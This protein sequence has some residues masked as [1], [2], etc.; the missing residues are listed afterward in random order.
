MSEVGVDKARVRELQ[1]K[2]LSFLDDDASNNR[3]PSASTPLPPPM[4]P[5]RKRKLS[6]SSHGATSGTG[7]EGP[8]RGSFGHHAVPG[9]LT[10]LASW[11]TTQRAARPVPGI[12][13]KINS[14]SSNTT[15]TAAASNHNTSSISSTTSSTSSLSGQSKSINQKASNN[16][17]N[18]ISAS[19]NALQSNSSKAAKHRYETSLGQLTKKFITLLKQAPEGVLNLNEA[20]TMLDVQKRRIYD[21]TNVLEGV[22]LLEKTSKN[23]IRWNGGLLDED[24]PN[25]PLNILAAT[26]SSS[27]LLLD[28]DEEESS[29]KRKIQLLLDDIDA[30]EKMLDE[31]I[32]LATNE[33]NESSENSANKKYAYVTYRDIRGIKEFSD[34]T[35]IAIKA[36]SE[37]KLEVPDPR[38]SLQIWLKSD[39]GE[40]E[41]YLCPED[42]VCSS[43]SR[44]FDEGKGESLATDM[45][46]KENRDDTEKERENKYSSAFISEDEDMAPIGSN[47]KYQLPVLTDDHSYSQASAST[48][49]A[50]FA[51]STL[52]FLH[53]E[54]PLSEEDYNFALEESEGLADLFDDE[55]L[56]STTNG[57]PV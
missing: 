9:I 43:P 28:C 39:R 44:S 57:S 27:A 33:L 45:E 24:D 22:G 12:F 7:H 16:L 47:R 42:E 21:I 41:V 2:F 32:Q 37:T 46:T 35:V 11:Q 23:N 51:V 4:T 20:S 54:P 17:L 10:P 3:S 52:P 48:S 6:N 1:K 31:M 18:N 34:Q 40:I 30:E 55:L 26:P 15:T 36:P 8:S 25:S 19:T 38:E 56:L 29:E 53:L 50:D 14:S 5:S 13:S 49:A